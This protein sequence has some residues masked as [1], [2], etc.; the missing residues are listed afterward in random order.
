MSQ[1]CEQETTIVVHWDIELRQA[2]NKKNK[3][4]CEARN[5]GN[6]QNKYELK[7]I[8]WCRPHK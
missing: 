8:I 4:M 5:F 6:I 1:F 3:K 2:Q 7:I